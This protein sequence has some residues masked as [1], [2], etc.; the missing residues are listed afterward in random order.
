MFSQCEIVSKNLLI[1]VRCMLS[2]KL[3][4]ADDVIMC[5]KVVKYESFTQFPVN[6]PRL[7]SSVD[8]SRL[9]HTND[10]NAIIC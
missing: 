10:K 9:I 1:K 4:K 3:L 8:S 5:M 6:L 7:Q 2:S